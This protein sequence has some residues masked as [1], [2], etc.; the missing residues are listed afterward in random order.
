VPFLT[1]SIDR[2]TPYKI[3]IFSYPGRLRAML[4]LRHEDSPNS[5]FGNI[6]VIEHGKR[7]DPRRIS[8]SPDGHL[9][10]ILGEDAQK[11]RVLL[12]YKW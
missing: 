12:V 1:P 3:L 4:P 7:Y 9:V 6:Y 2:A 11:H 5:P 8:L 10:A